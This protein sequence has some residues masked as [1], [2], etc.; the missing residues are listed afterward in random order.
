MIEKTAADVREQFQSGDIDVEQLEQ[1]Y[2]GYSDVDDVKEFVSKGVEKFP[3]LCCGLA[4][5]YLKDRLG[6][7]EVI[8]GSYS[9][10]NHTFLRVDGNILDIT[11]DQF[12]GPK[13]YFGPPEKPWSFEKGEL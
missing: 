4:S 6:K 9:D 1:L 12:G 2:S 7:G 3:E 11:A 10:K 8:N 5:I 13:L